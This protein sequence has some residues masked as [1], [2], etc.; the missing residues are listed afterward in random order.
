MAEEVAKSAYGNTSEQQ[1]EEGL[2]LMDILSLCLSKWYW[3]VFSVVLCAIVAVLYIKMTPPTYMRTASILVKEDDKGSNS[4]DLAKLGL[5]NTAT[6]VNNEI[7]TLRSQSV[8]R[9][10]I[11]RLG[12][13]VD[14]YVD[15]T[16]Y[17]KLLY[18]TN[19]PYTIHFVDMDE[20][21]LTGA[22]SVTKD[23]FKLELETLNAESSE[24][25][26]EGKLNDTIKFSAGSLVVTRNQAYLAQDKLP[27]E[28]E[29]VKK[30]VST[31]VGESMANLAVVLQDQQ[32][33]VIDISYTDVSTQRAADFVNTLVQVYNENWVKEKNQIS[34]STS[35][36]IAERLA[37]IEKELGTVESD[38]SSYKSSNRIPS[39]EAASALYFSKSDATAD[40]LMDLNNHKTM[41]NFVR[42]QLR[43]DLFK[44]QSIPSN[45]G[46]D[47][48]EIERMIS[49]YNNTLFTRNT[50]AANG[51]EQNP[52]VLEQETKL[53][54]TRKVILASL[55][56]Y[57]YSIDSQIRMLESKVAMANNRLAA[58]PTQEKYLLSVERQQKVKES[59]YLF[60]LQKREENEMGQAFTAYNT[61]IIDLANGSSIPVAPDSKKILMIALAI[62]L[63]VPIAWIYL[64]EVMNTTVRGHQDIEKLT[65]PYIGEIPYAL[66]RKKRR[67][68]WLRKLVALLRSIKHPGKRKHVEEVRQIVVRDRARDYINEAFR[69]VRTNLE[70]ML[71]HNGDKVVM[72]S[73]FNAG[74]G[75]TFLG[76]N[77]AMSYAIKG[78]KTVVVDLDLRKASLS[79]YVNS[80][81]Q[82]VAEYLNGD[83][84]DFH[85]IIV[86]GFMR[87]ELDVIPCGALPP[88]PAELLYSANLQKMIEALRQEYD[89]VFLDCPPAE[90]LADASIIN[91]YVDLTIFVI[92]A[93]LFDR[94]LLPKLESMYKEKRYKNMAT[95]LNGTIAVGSKYGYR[96]YGYYSKY[97]YGYG[98]GYSYGSGD[99]YG[100]TASK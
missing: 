98:Y 36:F 52:L 34:V 94:S 25:V 63:V 97:G 48:A 23:K 47:N 30:S 81:E 90:M 20:K 84:K 68:E 4:R 28:I 82:G 76:M 62:G 64:M 44:N 14:Y 42:Q 100:G 89:Y 5:T 55:D 67:F 18:G 50:L 56:N 87:D 31:A 9:G 73:S 60:L 2:G 12:M 86:K 27:E 11:Q 19:L 69:V 17:K 54:E 39:A 8:V 70:F 74:S 40:Q 7:L 66:K 45:S 83:V 92:R 99:A 1:E 80:P 38:I 6:N 49:E 41:A 3:I 79:T 77:L 65:V 21:G 78:K 96:K 29:I 35:Q 33:T 72:T 10:V 22:I 53:A 91:K 95:L 16:F 57:I 71:G 59:L 46:I 24:E 32:T 58:S 85:E 37:V 43:N 93:E 13:D 15:G 75:K 88:N 51:N 61:R 26:I